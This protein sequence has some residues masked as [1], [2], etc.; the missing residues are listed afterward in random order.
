MRVTVPVGKDQHQLDLQP[1]GSRDGKR[2]WTARCRL[3]MQ[4]LLGGGLRVAGAPAA[5]TTQVRNAASDAASAAG[6]PVLLEGY[7]SSTSVDWHGTEMTREAL[8][9]MAR[10]MAGGIPYVPGHYEDEWEQVMGRTVDARVEHGTVVRDGATMQQ[11]E[12]YRLAVRVEVYPEHPRAQLLL[13]AMKRGQVVGMSIG[14]WFTDAEVVTN[15]N[16]EVER[17]YIKAVEL[18]HLAVTRRPSNPDSWISGLA[19]TTGQALAAARAA[20]GV[21]AMDQRGMNV[22][23]SVNVVQH[24]LETEYEGAENPETETEAEDAEPPSSADALPV[25]EPMASDRAIGDAPAYRLSDSRTQ[26]CG[27]C[28]HRTRDGWCKA[29]AFACSSEWVCDGWQRATVDELA[30]GGSD[31]NA[32]TQPDEQRAAGGNMDLP[33]AP[34]DTAWGWDT[35]TANEVLGDPPDWERY[36]MAHLWVDTAN[37]ERRASFKL[38]FAKMVNGELHIVFRGVAAAMGALNG[39]R[40]G[41]DIPDS[42]RADVYERIV[43][44]YARFDKQPPELRAGDTA[45]DTAGEQG[46][47]ATSQ[48]D[49]VQS[50][51]LQPPHSEDNAMPDN[52]TATDTQRLD[53]L[54]RAIGELNGVL[55][56]LV[57]RVAPLELGNSTFSVYI[58]PLSSLN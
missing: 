4:G 22:Q 7:A 19:R 53:T 10:Q 6:G 1:A 42:D 29:F 44:L 41:V 37:P 54:E 35:D 46:S 2:V 8:D 55:A 33:L 48:S 27:T 36:A 28:T 3:P 12:G 20:G 17:I 43:A 16:D 11:S 50:A 49:A 13:G 40:G 5:G 57:E 25:Q 52:R 26:R 38:P 34:E 21:G 47:T 45:L 51:A 14:G 24:Q 31:G 39:A 56:K 9:S 32:P 30:N 58:V 23:V 15:E 18:D